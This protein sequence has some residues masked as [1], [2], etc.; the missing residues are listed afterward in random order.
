MSKAGLCIEKSGRAQPTSGPIL[1]FAYASAVVLIVLS[2]VRS[3]EDGAMLGH[4]H[5]AP[6]RPVMTTSLTQ[7]IA[8]EG[9]VYLTSRA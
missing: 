4:G 3:H 8:I 9:E 7:K 6:A 1:E 2:R 5:L